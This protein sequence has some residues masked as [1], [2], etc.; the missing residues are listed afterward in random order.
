MNDSIPEFKS[1][2]EAGS[3]YK[4]KASSI[5]NAMNEFETKTNSLKNTMVEIQNYH[6]HDRTC[7]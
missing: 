3:E 7:D 4:N 5:E 6:Q 1:F 2:V